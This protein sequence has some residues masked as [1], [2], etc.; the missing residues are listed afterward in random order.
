VPVIRCLTLIQ[1]MAAAIVHGTKRIENR[2]NN[3]PKAM[4]GVYSIVG[5]HAGK[6][7]SS[8]YELTCDQI[9]GVRPPDS[10]FKIVPYQRHV[11]DQG[12][13]GL[14]LL[15]GRVFTHRDDVGAFRG[16]F[17][18][19]AR[20]PHPAGTWYG[21]PYGYEIAD[22]VAFKEP[23]PC[24]GMLGFWTLP[25]AVAESQAGMQILDGINKLNE[26]RAA[27]SAA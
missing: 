27:R 24:R 22:A 18:D 10:V 15:T 20:C 19:G 6:S 1:P 17:V 4:R 7:Y 5:V 8:V 23:I 21:G 13:V 16:Y 25:D 9:D 12:L 14:M 11:H 2:T 26:V 3:L